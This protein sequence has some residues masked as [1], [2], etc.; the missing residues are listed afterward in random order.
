VGEEITGDT[1]APPAVPT[2]VPALEGQGGR[3]PARALEGHGGGAGTSS[4]FASQE[5]RTASLP[6][7][8][9]KDEGTDKSR[10][11]R[12]SLK[13]RCEQH[14]G[15]V[16]AYP[17]CERRRAEE[18]T[19]KRTL[20]GGEA[21]E[22]NPDFVDRPYRTLNAEKQGNTQT[23]FYRSNYSKWAWRGMINQNNRVPIT[24]G[25]FFFLSCCVYDVVWWRIRSFSVYFP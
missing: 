14:D 23:E 13:R 19:T 6:T 11:I 8:E 5:A 10:R 17:S 24:L 7:R 9:V 25:Q 21:K 12:P 16:Q 4:K 15:E 3:T 2:P 22:P 20:K 18:E 1:G